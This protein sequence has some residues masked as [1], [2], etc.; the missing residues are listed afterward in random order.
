MKNILHKAAFVV[1][2][3]LQACVNYEEKYK[4]Q[5][6]EID[7][8]AKRVEVLE[9]EMTSRAAAMKEFDTGEMEFIESF[10]KTLPDTVDFTSAEKINRFNS[11]VSWKIKLSDTLEY[12]AEETVKLYK[13]LLDFCTDLKKGNVEENKIQI[14]FVEEKTNA[15]NIINSKTI[16]DSLISEKTLIFEWAREQVNKTQ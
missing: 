6:E 10:N 15:E 11:I 12:F 2:I 7:S 5:I 4:N 9:N 8:L 14:Y 1:I 16:L 3:L 13:R